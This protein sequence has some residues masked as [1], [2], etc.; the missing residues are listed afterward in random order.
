MANVITG[1]HSASFTRVVSH[2]ENVAYEY[3]IKFFDA[4]KRKTD[5]LMVEI[6]LK[7]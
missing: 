3:K 5:S 4:G 6:V 2:V 1:P 7:F